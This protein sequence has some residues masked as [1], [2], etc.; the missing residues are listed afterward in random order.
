MSIQTVGDQPEES[1]LINSSPKKKNNNSSSRYLRSRVSKLNFRISLAWNW[2]VVT[3]P[4]PE[5]KPSCLKC[6][7]LCQVK[8]YYE[9]ERRRVIKSLLNGV[10][11]STPFAKSYSGHQ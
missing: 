8:Q 3:S 9:P 11:C 6:S 5:G 4:T 7:K 1:G 2:K 10:V